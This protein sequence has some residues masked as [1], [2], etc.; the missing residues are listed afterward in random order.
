M[1]KKKYFIIKNDKI[2]EKLIE[3]EFNPGFAIVQKQKNIVNIHKEILKKEGDIH[4]ILEVSSKS[5]EDIGIK[6][7]AFNLCIKTKK[8]EKI[9][10]ESIFQGS[11]V[12]E[13]GGP[14]I[15]LIYRNSKDA[16]KDERLKNSGK[17][18]KFYYNSESWDIEPK[19]IFYDWIYIN[20][21]WINIKEK[22]IDINLILDRDI[23]TDVEFNHEKSLNCQA[24]S[25]AL[26]IILYKNKI[27]EE[28]LEN[29]AK[30]IE[31]CKNI[32]TY[33]IEPQSKIEKN[34]HLQMGFKNLHL[35]AFRK[36]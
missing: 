33:E 26:F 25:V 27:L 36:N 16:K 15:E 19:T 34:L 3:Y 12:F 5:M 28:C 24:R 4:K 29:R 31:I 30:F 13:N 9:S 14:Y 8:A 22:I 23:F 10:V 32:Y 20:S 2:K 1:A 18:I 35:T 11:K 17:L 6:L 7:S 21:L